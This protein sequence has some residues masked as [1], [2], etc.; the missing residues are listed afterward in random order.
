MSFDREWK[1]FRSFIPPFLKRA[2][3]LESIKRAV[4]LDRGEM[5]GTKPKPLLL[6]RVA[7]EIL[8]PAFVIPSTRADVCFAGHRRECG[9][10]LSAPTESSS[11][12][13]TTLNDLSAILFCLHHLR[14]V[15]QELHPVP[16]TTLCSTQ[17]VT[18]STRFKA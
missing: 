7:V 3:R 17:R 1:P 14:P 10:R 12:S 2:L 13:T 15:P 16:R 6:R 5:L 8:P 9:N 11:S 4:H 18:T